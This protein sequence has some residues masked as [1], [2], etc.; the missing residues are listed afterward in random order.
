[1]KF[2]GKTQLQ[3]A[4][5]SP[6]KVKEGELTKLTDY[7]IMNLRGFSPSSC[8]L[9]SFFAHLPLQ[10]HGH[11]LKPVTTQQCSIPAVLH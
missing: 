3:R 1:M 2:P 5:S 9:D 11:S 10:T 6:C 4:F 7:L 8:I